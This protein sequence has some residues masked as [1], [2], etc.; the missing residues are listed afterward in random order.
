MSVVPMNSIDA[1]RLQP[2]QYVST[3]EVGPIYGVYCASFCNYATRYGLERPLVAGGKKAIPEAVHDAVMV[4][5]GFKIP[6]RFFAA[7]LFL[8]T[9]QKKWKKWQ[10]I[11]NSNRS[12]VLLIR[13]NTIMPRVISKR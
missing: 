6:Y 5:K 2:G 4:W 13:R 3:D 8:L 9:I 7:I 1:R 12:S 11:I 10:K